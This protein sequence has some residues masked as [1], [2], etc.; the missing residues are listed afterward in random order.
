M[1]GPPLQQSKIFFGNA[2]PPMTETFASQLSKF[3]TRPLKTFLHRLRVIKSPAEIANMREAGRI[4][5]RVFNKAMGTRFTKEKDLWAFLDYGFRVG[6]C[7]KEAYVP[8]VAGGRNAL[9][10]HYTRNEDILRWVLIHQLLSEV[11]AFFPT[12]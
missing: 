6:G 4:S 5:G 11:R 10:I 7:E 12:G 3:K 1:A 9:S 8:V 2:K